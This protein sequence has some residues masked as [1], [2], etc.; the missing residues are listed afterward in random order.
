VPI[1]HDP[2]FDMLSGAELIA[3]S[4]CFAICCQLDVML[5]DDNDVPDYL[6][7]IDERGQTTMAK[8]E[9][10]WCAAMDPNTNLCTIYHQRPGVCRDYD[11]GGQECV[12]ERRIYIDSVSSLAPKP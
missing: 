7:A 1:V 5:I 2:Q 12:D 9:S 6:I 3:C 8:A 10:G 4:N 11:M